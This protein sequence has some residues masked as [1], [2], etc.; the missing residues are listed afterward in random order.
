LTFQMAQPLDIPVLIVGGGIVGLSASLFLSHHGIRSLLVERHSGTSIHPRARGFN[1]RTMELFRELSVDQ[2]VR[3]AGAELSPSKG[4]YRGSSLVEVIEPKKRSPEG[5]RSGLPTDGIVKAI[6]PVAGARATQDFV[7]PALL[8]AARTRQYADI[9]F[10]TE[11]AEFDQ[12]EDGVT[13]EIRDR[14]SGEKTTVRAQ[15]LLAADGAGGRV[16][17]KLGIESTGKGRL[18]N[19][20][21]ILF[22]ADLRELVRGREFSLCRISRP[23]ILGLFTS[24][25]NSNWWAFH[26]SYDPDKGEKAKNYTKEHCQELVK[27]ALGM[28]QADVKIIAAL[29]WEPSAR[30]AKT[31]KKG[32]VFLAG[33]AAHQVTPWRGQ[34]ATSGVAEVHNLAWKLA[35]VLKGEAKS[36]LLETYD[37]ERLPVGRAAAQIS[38]DAADE[39]GLLA[40]NMRVILKTIPAAP[41][42]IGFGY[43]YNSSAIIPDTVPY[44][45]IPWYPVA[46]LLDLQ[47]KPGTRVPHLWVQRGDEQIS[48]LDVC[49]KNFVLLAGQD[50]QDAWHKAAAKVTDSLAINILV[51]AIG[52]SGDMVDSNNQW[53]YL[54][55]ITSNGA[56][57]VRPDG[58]VAWRAYSQPTQPAERLEQVMKQTLFR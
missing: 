36:G 20:I 3:D 26:L 32:R 25:N 9:R 40:T 17:Q 46:W 56:L 15:Y 7:E 55:G 8:K 37:S 47:G 30:V 6:S 58:F 44:F 23:G 5:A 50:D 39:H 27:L 31:L 13:A 14:E 48:T 41:R 12:D 22:E 19:L 34:G 28:P 33:D 45:R 51:Y 43:S 11:C 21:N 29:P 1:A 35:A 54:A 10:Y 38:A 4:I 53:L 16:R 18:G 42:I 52:P 57:L 24:I 49:G 2:L